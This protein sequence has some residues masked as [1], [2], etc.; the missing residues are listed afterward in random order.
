MTTK[1]FFNSSI[2]EEDEDSKTLEEATTGEESFQ[3]ENLENH[4]FLVNDIHNIIKEECYR[5]YY[6][7]FME[8][9][10]V[11]KFLNMLSKDLDLDPLTE[12]WNIC[13]C[14]SRTI[15]IHRMETCR[16]LKKWY[17]AHKDLVDLIYLN[18]LRELVSHNT[19]KKYAFITSSECS[20]TGSA[21][22]SPP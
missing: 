16:T 10:D 21:K 4:V 5:R 13:K 8:K 1:A 7:C 19:W 18:H 12:K 11:G 20:C 3:K 14:E 15:P 6:G 17:D 9:S 22:P 2:W